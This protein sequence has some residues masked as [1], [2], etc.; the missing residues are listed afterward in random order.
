MMKSIGSCIVIAALIASPAWAGNDSKSPWTTYGAPIT[1]EK[2][3]RLNTA[4]TKN[5]GREV[6]IQGK[7][8]SVCQNKGCW[9]TVRD[10]NQE[11]RVEF[12]D[13]GFF[14]PWKTEGKPVRMQGVVQE[15]AMSPEEQA[16]IVAESKDGG[17]VGTASPEPRKI[18]VF[19]ASGVSIQGGGEISAEQKQRIGGETE[20]EA[21]DHDHG[22]PDHKH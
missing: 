5:L 10:G 17:G 1:I 6:M 12:K 4:T 15:K 2:T 21:K 16:H 9:M 20:A 18:R 11:I 3:T 7:I 19:V 22:G 8:A 13:Y 14:V